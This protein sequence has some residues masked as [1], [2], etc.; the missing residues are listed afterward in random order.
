MNTPPVGACANPIAGQVRTTIASARTTFFF[1]SPPLARMRATLT[2]LFDLD[3]L[4]RYPIGPLN[5]CGPSVAKRVDLLEEP[6]TFIRQP[7]HHRP[8]I[9]NAE[10]PVID[11][12]PARADEPAAGPWPD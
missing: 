7:A 12:V 5:H 6:D 3:E 4:D 9:G 11:D 10:R 2:R 1:T 8:K